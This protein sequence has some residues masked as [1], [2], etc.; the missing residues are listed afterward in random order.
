MR[1]SIRIAD[2]I[3]QEK[4]MPLLKNEPDRIFTYKDYL[5]WN[6]NERCELING[7]AY[8]MAQLLL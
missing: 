8:N 5:T 7:V 3:G 6:D 1:C 4:I 2:K